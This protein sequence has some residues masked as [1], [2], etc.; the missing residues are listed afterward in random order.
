MIRKQKSLLKKAISAAL[1][2][3]MVANLTPSTLLANDYFVEPQDNLE[4]FSYSPNYYIPLASFEFSAY[5][6]QLADDFLYQTG[7]PRGLIQLM[8]ESQRHF[9]FSE[10]SA[11]A[12]D[13]SFDTY[14]LQGFELDFN[15]NLVLAYEFSFD[16]EDLFIPFANLPSWRLTLTAPSFN[17]ANNHLGERRVQIFTSFIWSEPENIRNDAFAV[18]LGQGWSVEPRGQTNNPLQVRR[19]AANGSSVVT[20]NVNQHNLNSSIHGYAWQIPN[21][22]T[23]NNQGTTIRWEGHS[24]LIAVSASNS[25][26]IIRLAY[27]HVTPALLNGA[28]SL[29][30][31][32]SPISISISPLSGNPRIETAAGNFS[33]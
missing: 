4:D 21:T 15:E 1:A 28:V 31:A 33:F 29:S 20:A 19:V 14:T 22:A 10:L 3:L 2:L 9:I 24:T 18:A 16:A 27:S 17:L 30:I 11:Q 23:F 5:D 25:N 8:P 13:I 32:L 7:M 6:V 26:R 12:Y